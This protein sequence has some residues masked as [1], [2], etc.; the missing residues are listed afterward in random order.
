[1]NVSEHIID[2]L[3]SRGFEVC[4]CNPGTS[5][6]SF[7]EALSKQNVKTILCLHENVATGAA[8]GY[9]IISGYNDNKAFALL[10]TGVGLSNGLSNLH[11]A[12]KA[13]ICIP[14]IVGKQA[15][16]HIGSPL[17]QDI[18]TIAC[19][20]SDNIFQSGVSSDLDSFLCTIDMKVSVL[21]IDQEY[22]NYV[23]DCKY[24]EKCRPSTVLQ[25]PYDNTTVNIDDILT[26]CK[27]KRGHIYVDNEYL[28]GE[29]L[30]QIGKISFNFNMK[31]ICKTNAAR[32]ERGI[33][34][35]NVER[36]PYFPWTAKS[37]FRDIEFVICFADE[38]PSTTF[39]YEGFPGS[40]FELKESLH[41]LYIPFEFRKS[42]VDTLLKSST[43]PCI[44]KSCLSFP[45]N[46][47][48]P[49]KAENVCSILA[50]MQPA[51]C[52]VVD[53]SLTCGSSYWE[54]SHNSPNF[55]HL[56]LAGGS[57]G[58]G[59]PCALGVSLAFPNE[60]VINL[61]ADGSFAYTS[62]SL[63]TQ[64][65]CNCNIITILLKNCAYN[66]LKLE[67]KIQN[68]AECDVFKHS[69]DLLDPVI[70]WKNIAEGYGIESYSVETSTEFI[71]ILKQ[72]IG[73]TTP[74]FIEVCLDSQ[75]STSRMPTNEFKRSCFVENDFP[76]LIDKIRKEYILTLHVDSIIDKC[77]HEEDESS[78][79]YYESAFSLSYSRM[80]SFSK[81]VSCEIKKFNLGEN[82]TCGV[83]MWNCVSVLISHFALSLS[84]LIAVNVNPRLTPYEL[85]KQFESSK[86]NLI[87][88]S[89][90]HDQLHEN[91][92]KYFNSLPFLLIVEP[93]H[94]FSKINGIN[95]CKDDGIHYYINNPNDRNEDNI[96]Q[97]FFTSGSTG[98]S[99]GVLM[100]QK[101]VC[102]HAICA[103]NIEMGI[104]K[105]DSWGHFAPMYHSVDSFSIYSVTLAQGRHVFPTSNVFSPIDTLKLIQNAKITC[106]NLPPT[107]L[108]FII[109]LENIKNFDLTSMRIFSC[110]GASLSSTTLN[111]ISKIFACEFF[112]SYG[113]TECCGKI[114]MSIVDRK[115]PAHLRKQLTNTS[116]RP[117]ILIDVRVEN[118]D[119]FPVS[120]NN[121]E[122]G[123]VMIR[124]PTVFKGYVDNTETRNFEDEWFR[125]GDLAIVNEYGYLTIVGRKKD[126]I[127]VSGENVVPTE[128]EEIIKE[129]LFVRDA[130]VFGIPHEKFGECVV[131]A[132]TFHD[133]NHMTSEEIISFCS[134]KLAS[135]KI[136]M[137][138]IEMKSFDLTST[139][140]YDKVKIK[141]IA[142]KQ[143]KHLNTSDL[144]DKLSIRNA[145]DINSID[146]NNI[147]LESFCDILHKDKSSLSLN[148]S[149][150]DLGGDSIMATRLNTI[151]NE[152]LKCQI[153]FSAIVSNTTVLDITA[154]VLKTVKENC[155]TMA[156]APNA[157]TTEKHS[158]TVS[159][160]SVIDFNHHIQNLIIEGDLSTENEMK[161]LKRNLYLTFINPFFLS[162]SLNKSKSSKDI[163]CTK[164]YPEVSLQERY[165]KNLCEKEAS[166]TN[167]IVRTL[168][169]LSGKVD[170]S[171]FL[172]ILS[173]GLNDWPFLAG[174]YFWDRGICVSYGEGDFIP[175]F[176]ED[177]SQLNHDDYHG[178]AQNCSVNFAKTFQ[179]NRYPYYKFCSPVM[180]IVIT[181]IQSKSI[182]S[183]YH[184]H[185]AVTTI[186]ICQFLEHCINVYKGDDRK[187]VRNLLC[188]EEYKRILEVHAKSKDSSLIHAKHKFEL[189]SNSQFYKLMMFFTFMYNFS[190]CVLNLIYIFC[191]S[192]VSICLFNNANALKSTIRTYVYI[193]YTFS[194]RDIHFFEKLANK[195]NISII[196]IIHGYSI[197][198]AAL[199]KRNAYLNIIS[200]YD[201]RSIFPQY[202][203][204]EHVSGISLQAFSEHNYSWNHL[205]SEQ[206]IKLAKEGRNDRLFDLHA[207]CSRELDDMVNNAR[208]LRQCKSYLMYFFNINKYLFTP[209]F[210]KSKDTDTIVILNNFAFNP[211]SLSGLFSKDINLTCDREYQVDVNTANPKS[212]EYL[213]IYTD[214]KQRLGIR[215]NLFSNRKDFINI[216]VKL[217]AMDMSNL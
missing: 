55:I 101:Q 178:F 118:E 119:G 186:D 100:T 153:P 184:S 39:K 90:L 183:F 71:E 187:F 208:L 121:K 196:D 182:I 112:I 41:I 88:M 158:D 68:A 84:S 130:L 138:V 99:K 52:I 143:M 77:V 146:I 144:S 205:V 200:N 145:D 108:T 120:F 133:N 9:N 217:I 34:F 1:M 165:S 167:V 24:A 139:G 107:F 214:C 201:K 142:S 111:K 78:K 125:T 106:T 18:R 203:S 116:G 176:I 73:K 151:L 170:I 206:P 113:M 110:G 126:I 58:F 46:F 150:F 70:N 30:K 152:R 51:N 210:E 3:K 54:V 91:M 49:L 26:L 31:I 181:T 202:F 173:V 169:H 93:G 136:P 207:I 20:V 38:A 53:E 76:T 66:I 44:K 140:K 114:S 83:Y 22:Q 80:I 13:N 19:A 7:L 74:V 29:N 197:K 42:V 92:S 4:F 95:V 161:D 17:E 62:Q 85:K 36:L 43:K 67:G 166:L 157:K 162:N 199:S 12:K 103:G 168:F 75:S 59:P 61:Q 179:T 177:Q 156:D 211:I 96:F 57:I 28:V 195:E 185:A 40:Y 194:S 23:A 174:K 98:N 171:H 8:Y 154:M 180:W 16:T 163:S 128:I 155:T 127:I 21:I 192:Y 87:L 188:R 14:V 105:N 164:L 5:E 69:T 94:S 189:K 160:D 32:I 209:F 147:V 11:N 117:F 129:N 50:C 56:N 10:H 2:K 175:V 148:A 25:D 81:L 45:G 97:I 216:L 109:E 35:P 86:V 131:A 198:A 82:Q 15:A 204:R 134:K 104:T 64:A 141:E 102:L 193:N 79:V 215:G 122:V 65:K 48:E 132:V 47:N 191:T 72:S 190:F 149:F 63:W 124:G 89:S 115:W 212:C 6:I 33:D 159:S 137:E 60:K 27:S 37:L 172:S 123:E 135:Y 213:E